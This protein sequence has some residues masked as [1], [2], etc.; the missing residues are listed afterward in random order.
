MN[1]KVMPPILTVSSI[2]SRVVPWMSLTIALSS[3][4]KTLSNV[5]F[6]AFVSPIMA[7]GTPLL[8]ALPTLNELT[9]RAMT[10]SMLFASW[11]SSERSANSSSSWSLKS[12]SNSMSEVKWSN[13]SRKVASSLLKPP[14]IWLMARRWVAA[15]DEAI[16]SATASAW[17]RSI[18]PFRNARWVYSPGAAMRQ[19]FLM[20]SCNTF[21][22]I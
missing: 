11:Q 20:S 16:R 19:P 15:D 21:W 22:R 12:N 13:W 1:L 2:I 3:L 7:T 4:S 5:D 17:L 14:R 18:F 9:K 8:M 6:P 10:F